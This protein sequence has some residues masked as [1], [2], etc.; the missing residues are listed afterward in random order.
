VSVLSLGS[1]A[2]L[3]SVYGRTVRA[4]AQRAGQIVVGYLIV[5]YSLNL[6]L[7]WLRPPAVV[8]DVADWLDAGNPW[9]VGRQI[10]DALRG[11]WRF[12]DAALPAIGRYLLFHLVATGVFL[13]W[14]AR[15]LRPMAALHAEGPPLADERFRLFRPPTRPPVP[16]RPVLWKALHFDFRQVRSVGGQ[17]MARVVFVLSFVPVILILAT[18]FI[19]KSWR[20]L[21]ELINPSIVR[22]L[23]TMV[24]CGLIVMI[25]ANSSACIGVERRKKTYDELVL[26]DLTVEEILGQKWWASII[27]VRWALVW[28]GVHWLIAVVSGGL[29]PLAMPLLA[30]EWA[31][32]AS[33]AASLGVYCAARWP[34]A[35]KAGVYTGVLGFAAVATP[36]FLSA[37]IAL[38]TRAPTTHNLSFTLPVSASPPVAL[39]LSGFYG[40]EVAELRRDYPAA[41]VSV[42]I[43]TATSVLVAAILAWRLWRGACRRFPRA[44]G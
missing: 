16:D 40:T 38:A 41:L 22:G 21:P 43:G 23:A 28:V 10:A 27:V 13:T 35:R 26:T 7:L 6:A 31:A 11:G 17:A 34:Q 32:Y 3:C 2:I 44:V 20:Q 36:L 18:V 5:M 42:A 30:I 1:L 4:A 25:A 19:E 37:L 33:F 15:R 12:A 9:A 39:A 29:H 14:A 24:L 8:F